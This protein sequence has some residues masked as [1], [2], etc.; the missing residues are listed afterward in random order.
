MIRAVFLDMFNTLC[1]SH[2]PR[3]E[4]QVEAAEQ[5]GLHITP[6]AVRRAYVVG[7]DYWTRENA[8]WRLVDRPEEELA[9]FYAE[10]EKTLLEAAGAS[11]S[12]DLA[13]QVFQRY[14]QSPREWRLYDDVL[15]TFV[16]LRQQGITLGL[17]SNTDK[18]LDDLCVELGLTSWLD[19]R[20]Y[21]CDVGCEKPDPRI[22]HA[23]L[24]RAGV[25]AKEVV[26]VGDQYY[27]DIVGARGVGIL[28]LLI[29]R[30]G[31]LAHLDGC[32]RIRS[33]S[34]VLSFTAAISD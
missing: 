7:E 18:P 8:R 32:I 33:L 11:A 14:A 16:A 9:T 17:V 3:E 26:H 28:A 1:Y 25:G 34:D 31:F 12:A 23:A 15:P 20:L 19:F 5:F 27:S 24:E 2:P 6:E 21:S 10:Y 22:F 13:F 29:D 4:R 30:P